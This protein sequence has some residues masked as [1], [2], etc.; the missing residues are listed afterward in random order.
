MGTCPSG[1]VPVE[2]HPGGQLSGW[3][4]LVRN[5][6]VRSHPGRGIVPWGVV[7]VGELSVVLVGELSGWELSGA[8]LSSGE[9]S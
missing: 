1:L 8:E 3:D 7:L 6:P 4:Y 9:L 2:S 5:C